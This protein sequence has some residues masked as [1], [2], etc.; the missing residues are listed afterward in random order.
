M[1]GLCGSCEKREEMLRYF[2]KEALQASGASENV[3]EV[4]LFE[5]NIIICGKAAVWSL[6]SLCCLCLSIRCSPQHNAPSAF[7]LSRLWRT[8]CLKKGLRWVKGHTSTWTNKISLR[9][10]HPHRQTSKCL[11]K[12]LQT[13]WMTWCTL[14]FLSISSAGCCDQAAGGDLSY[15]ALLLPRS[16]WGCRWQVQQDGAGRHPGLRHPSGHLRSHPPV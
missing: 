14:T 6:Y 10:A 3:S 13:V 4:Q 2:V 11:Q 5:E 16:V 9:P 1:I 8:C 15:F 7:F 12:A